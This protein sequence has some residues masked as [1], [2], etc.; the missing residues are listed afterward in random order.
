ML[1]MLLLLRCLRGAV[2]RES[3]LP[4]QM[5]RL[6]DDADWC[7]EREITRSMVVWPAA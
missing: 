3:R 4:Y 1:L 5:V 6:S 2:E 7:R